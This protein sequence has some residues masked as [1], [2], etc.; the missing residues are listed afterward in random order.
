M[1]DKNMSL[2]TLPARARYTALPIGTW[3]KVAIGHDYVNVSGAMVERYHGLTGRIMG[4]KRYNELTSGPNYRSNQGY[5]YSVAFARD[6]KNKPVSEWRASR[7]TWRDHMLVVPQ[8][9]TKTKPDLPD[10]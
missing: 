1:V 2:E 8:E 7:W 9:V 6:N 3:V 4:Y 10:I 5:G